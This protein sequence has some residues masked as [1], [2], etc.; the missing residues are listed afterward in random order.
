MMRRGNALALLL[1]LASLPAGP[2][3]RL[4]SRTRRTPGS[5]TY[6]LRQNQANQQIQV[7]VSGGD[8]VA[9]VNFNMELGNGGTQMGQPPAPS[10]TNLDLVT[11]T[12][13]QADYLDPVDSGSTPDLLTAWVVTNSGTVPADG[14]LATVTV[15][16]TGFFASDPVHSWLLSMNDTANEA[17]GIRGQWGNSR[18]HHRWVDYAWR[19]RTFRRGLFSIAVL[20]MAGYIAWH[21]KQ[22]PRSTALP[23]V[24]NKRTGWMW[25]QIRNETAPP[26]SPCR[27]VG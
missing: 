24:A 10:F 2:S 16:T 6:Q 5:H 1:L 7:Y 22:R 14:L 20:V 23:F 18:K 25:K 15:D 12:I 21:R 4:W 17:H 11:G 13:F 9:G 3:R 8:P 26:F 27:L 19:R